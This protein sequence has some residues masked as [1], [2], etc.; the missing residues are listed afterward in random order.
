MV[1]N[2]ASTQLA[3]AMKEQGIT[4]LE[5][6]KH[7]KTSERQVRRL[8]NPDH[9]PLLSSLSRAAAIVGRRVLVR[10]GRGAEASE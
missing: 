6:T 10:L 1:I 7:L 2:K 5:M 3:E 4:V 8:L 9:N